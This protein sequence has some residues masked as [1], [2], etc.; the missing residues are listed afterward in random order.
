MAIGKAEE[1]RSKL[2]PRISEIRNVKWEF[3]YENFCRGINDF[4][5]D[6]FPPAVF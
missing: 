6:I 3:E 1:D 2:F 4:L 5:Q